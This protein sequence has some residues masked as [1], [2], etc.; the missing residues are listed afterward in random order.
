[1]FQ[2]AKRLI[3]TIIEL[4]ETL[5]RLE[6]KIDEKQD[7]QQFQYVPTTSDTI[8]IKWCD[9]EYPNPWFGTVPPSCKKCGQTAI[10]LF[11]TY[12]TSTGGTPK[13]TIQ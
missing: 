9:H 10:Q 4:P 8:T 7:K 3:K 6:A 1:M 12:T 5:E 2:R 11:P 13:Q